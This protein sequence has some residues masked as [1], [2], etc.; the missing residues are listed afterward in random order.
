MQC[1]QFDYNN[2]SIN[3]WREYKKNIL[4]AINCGCFSNNY[5]T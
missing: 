4:P 5:K 1:I 3:K 2:V